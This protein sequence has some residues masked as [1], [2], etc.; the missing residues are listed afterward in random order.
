MESIKS[1]R[2]LMTRDKTN[3]V[4]G[5]RPDSGHKGQLAWKSGWMNRSSLAP[6]YVSI[7]VKLGFHF[8]VRQ[9]PLS[10]TTT[11]IVYEVAILL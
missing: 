8:W 1:H 4:D 7:M 9:D 10:P 6:R 2:D 5:R 11:T 3:G